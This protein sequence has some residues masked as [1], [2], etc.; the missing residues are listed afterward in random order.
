[1]R[2]ESMKT[3]RSTKHKIAAITQNELALLRFDDKRFILE[4]EMSTLTHGHWRTK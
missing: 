4:D 3:F 1:M 2:Y